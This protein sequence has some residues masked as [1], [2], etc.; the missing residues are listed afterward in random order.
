MKLPTVFS[1]YADIKGLFLNFMYYYIHNKN[2]G[3][4]NDND[5]ITAFCW[6]D[7]SKNFKYTL[8]GQNEISGTTGGLGFRFTWILP[9]FKLYC[10]SFGTITKQADVFL[11]YRLRLRSV[12]WFLLNSNEL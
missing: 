1:A 10:S 12:L 2:I 3:N 4:D 6:Q 9:W 11:G 8:L 7:T 5:Q